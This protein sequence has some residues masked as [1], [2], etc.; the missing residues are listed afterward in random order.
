MLE[1]VGDGYATHPSYQSGDWP[2]ERRDGQ[3]KPLIP[4][5][6]GAY[7]KCFGGYADGLV[8]VRAGSETEEYHEQ[9][10]EASVGNEVACGIFYSF[11]SVNADSCDADQIYDYDKPIN[12]S[13][14][15]VVLQKIANVGILYSRWCEKARFEYMACQVGVVGVDCLSKI[16]FHTEELFAIC[17]CWSYFCCW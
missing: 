17:C 3:P 13:Y 12:Y 7:P 4:D 10:A 6:G 11:G 14:A 5:A 15:H 2:I 1:I 8:G 9:L 16:V